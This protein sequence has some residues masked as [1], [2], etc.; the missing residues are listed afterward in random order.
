ML[1][2]GALELCGALGPEP[3]WAELMKIVNAMK[4]MRG[5]MPLL[6]RSDRFNTETGIIKP[7]DMTRSVE[8]STGFIF[9]VEA[10][11]W[12]Y[13]NQRYQSRNCDKF[14]HNCILNARYPLEASRNTRGSIV[15]GE[16][17]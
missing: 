4:S 15:E 5:R 11:L 9:E 3:V 6:P 17:G 8:F 7:V 1:P 14:S 2:P 13:S 16:T 10:A 12:N